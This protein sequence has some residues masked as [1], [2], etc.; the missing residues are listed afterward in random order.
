MLVLLYWKSALLEGHFSNSVGR[1][2]NPNWNC[3]SLYLYFTPHF[4]L[5]LKLFVEF[6]FWTLP[7]YPSTDEFLLFF[8]KQKPTFPNNPVQ[9]T[10]YKSSSSLFWGT[11]SH[12]VT[13]QEPKDT[14]C[15]SKFT[16]SA[17]MFVA[18]CAP[19][20]D[21]FEAFHKKWDQTASS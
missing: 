3:I 7:E 19:V 20:R 15:A 18:W 1:A 5:I 21:I 13:D 17:D 2:S 4:Q 16:Y 12:T 6:I 8:P 14:V 11:F 9:R 10:V